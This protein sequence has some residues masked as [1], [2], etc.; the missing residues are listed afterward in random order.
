VAQKFFGQFWGNS[1]K[2]LSHPQKF[3]CSYTYEG[4]GAFLMSCQVLLMNFLLSLPHVNGVGGGGASAPPKVLICW[5]F[6]QNPGNLGKLPENTGKN[7]VQRLQNDME[8]ADLVFWSSSQ[9]K[10]FMIFVGENSRTKSFRATLWKFDQKLIT[11]PNI[12]LLLYTYA[13]LCHKIQRS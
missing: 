6:G 5:K 1:G 12:C 11:P 7:G 3:A 4:T 10:V 2:N 8:H 9:K 13:T